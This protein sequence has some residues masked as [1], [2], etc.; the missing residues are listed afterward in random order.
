MTPC[1]SSEFASLV[2]AK[3]HQIRKK[4]FGVKL[5]ILRIH[6]LRLLGL[7]AAISFMAIERLKQMKKSTTLMSC[8]SRIDVPRCQHRQNVIRKKLLDTRRQLRKMS[9]GWNRKLMATTLLKARLQSTARHV[10]W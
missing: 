2:A 7:F 9:V 5:E 3:K 10:C 4:D 6:I 8:E 1:T